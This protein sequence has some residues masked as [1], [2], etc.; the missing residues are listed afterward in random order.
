MPSSFH[1]SVAGSLMAVTLIMPLPTLIE[2]P[3]TLT[4]R[5]K[6]AV[7]GIEPQQMRIGFD[8]REIVDGDDLDV[9]A[10]CFGDGAEHVAADAPEP[11]DGDTN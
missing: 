5:G 3:T 2:S 10:V 1:G 11:V 9:P 8:R 7:H 6:A 4:S